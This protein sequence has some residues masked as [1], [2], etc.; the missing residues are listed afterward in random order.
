MSLLFT[1]IFR[2]RGRAQPGLKQSGSALS[3]G[4]CLCGRETPAIRTGCKY[5]VHFP[6][7]I[8][9]VP[10]ILV[11]PRGLRDLAQVELC[12]PGI[13]GTQEVCVLCR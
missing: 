11:L 4:S 1:S 5:T 3:L 9:H 7:E 12:C 13:Q 2:G 6:I 10:G 8:R